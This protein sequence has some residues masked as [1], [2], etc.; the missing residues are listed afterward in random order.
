MFHSYEKVIRVDEDEYIR[1]VINKLLDAG[2]S[3]HGYP[4]NKEQLIYWIRFTRD[5]MVDK[6][7]EIKK[8]IEILDDVL[9]ELEN[10]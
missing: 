7:S 2:I 1:N 3:I 10:E 4:E 5:A 6:A 8:K 9:K